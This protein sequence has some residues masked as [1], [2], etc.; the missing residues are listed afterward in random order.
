MIDFRDLVARYSFAEH[1]ARADKYFSSLDIGSPVARKPFAAPMEAAEICGGLAALLPELLLYPGARVLDFGAGT[2]WLSR[3]LAMLG[4]EV[5]AVDVSRKALEI[6]ERLIRSDPVGA[7]LRVQFVPLD[8][9]DLPFENDTFDRVV[10]FDA[11]HHVPDQQHAIREFGRVLKQGGIAALH[12]GGPKHSQ[13]SQSQYEMRMFGVIE[14]DVHVD[15]LFDVAR[16]A[17]FTSADLA[18][19]GSRA[20]RTD[21][22]GFDDFLAEPARSRVGQQFIAQTAAGFDNRRTF[23]LSKGDPAEAIDSRSPI[24]LL[25]DIDLTA[26]V[27]DTR[28]HLRGTI[29]N[30]GTSRWWPS[31][32]GIGAVNIGVHL[33]DGEGQLVDRDYGRFRISADDVASGQSRAVEFSV[34]HPS[35]LERFE[36]A[37]DLV[38]ECVAWFEVVGGTP[39]RF[40]VRLDGTP[41]VDRL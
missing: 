36:L 13:L 34:A 37:I 27:D 30:I 4:C 25:A 3:L 41:R 18:V 17:G 2:C 23:F 16:E 6:G 33:H 8:G 5:T 35:G 11:L 26:R 14:G 38:A 12:E 20:L 22:R 15:E 29:T 40:A 39:A 24:G 9:P 7:Q 21:L 19:Y 10:C 31:F 32:I 28:T 1:A